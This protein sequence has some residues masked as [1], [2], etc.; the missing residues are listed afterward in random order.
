MFASFTS[1]LVQ[2]PHP[3]ILFAL[4]ILLDKVILA[5]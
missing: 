5:V 3:D 2:R 1:D 4:Y